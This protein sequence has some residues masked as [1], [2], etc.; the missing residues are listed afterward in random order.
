MGDISFFGFGLEGIQF[1]A[2]D[3]PPL[4]GKFRK[5]NTL[6][7]TNIFAPENCW[8]KDE[9]PFGARPIFM[10]ELLVSGRVA[11]LDNSIFASG[12]PVHWQTGQEDDDFGGQTCNFFFFSGGE[13][14]KIE[15]QL[16]R[17]ICYKYIS[18]RIH[19]WYIY[20]Y[21]YHTNQP[22]M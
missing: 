9:F 15:F 14:K 5:N 11:I 13:W 8:L 4:K 16:N 22:F 10:G 1:S 2:L 18:H 3:D 17:Y 6:P 20:L 7:E 19:V 21:I 12:H